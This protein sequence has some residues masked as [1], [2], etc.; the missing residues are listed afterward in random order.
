MSIPAPIR[1][2][3]EHARP[4]ILSSFRKDSCIASTAISIKV[5]HHFGIK[6]FPVPV[7]M[8]V[9]NRM[10]VK[11]IEEVGIGTDLSKEEQLA[12]VEKGAWSVG[13][14][15][16]SVGHVVAC[17]KKVL[18]DL[19]IDQATRPARGIFLEPL[20][21]EVQETFFGGEPAFTAMNDSLIRY[22]T[23]PGRDNFLQ[24][25]DWT[26]GSRHEKQVAKT[27]EVLEKEMRKR[28]R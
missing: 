2:L 6:A 25:K 14:E 7:H 16:D 3:T 21:I 18:I 28:K 26:D 22:M 10:Y 19:S 15:D 24:S 4:I 1:L 17:T 8:D 11:M 27:I 9:F 23:N 13:V 12:W 20:A 5:L